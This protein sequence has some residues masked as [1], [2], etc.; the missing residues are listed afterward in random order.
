[1][2]AV[3]GIS[4]AGFEPVSQAAQFRYD[5]VKPKVAEFIGKFN[6]FYEKDLEAFK[7]LLKDSDFTLFGPSMPLKID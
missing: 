6:D 4:S 7:K 3:G 5:K 2:G 1:M